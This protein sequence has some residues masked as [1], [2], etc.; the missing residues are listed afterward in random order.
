FLSSMK[1]QAPL[2]SPA[3]TSTTNT[4]NRGLGPSVGITVIA[5]ALPCFELGVPSKLILIIARQNSLGRVPRRLPSGLRSCPPGP[6]PCQEA[7]QF[8]ETDSGS[9]PAA[10]TLVA[11][12]R[13]APVPA[14][15]HPP[16]RFARCALPS[17]SRGR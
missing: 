8:F 2:P 5:A 17:R 11:N 4:A 9:L 15:N 13:S 16:G 12:P 6:R 3:S 1:Y 14:T 7:A 10:R